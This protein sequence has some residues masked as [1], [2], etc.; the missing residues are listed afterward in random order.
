MALFKLNYL[1]HNMTLMQYLNWDSNRQKD[2]ISRFN[3]RLFGLVEE[4]H[5]FTTYMF[6]TTTLGDLV[7]GTW[8]GALGFLDRNEAD[9]VVTSV[10]LTPDRYGYFEFTTSNTYLNRFVMCLN[11]FKCSK[12]QL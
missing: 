3:Y 10:R 8:N 6:R 12:F 5:N 7:N 11:I 4:M 9:C 2:S 1:P